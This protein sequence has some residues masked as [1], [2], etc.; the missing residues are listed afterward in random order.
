VSI[1]DHLPLVLVR[2]QLQTTA[3]P[4]PEQ[5]YFEQPNSVRDYLSVADDHLHMD[6]AIGSELYPTPNTLIPPTAA[7]PAAYTGVHPQ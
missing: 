6:G 1:A 2:P 7:A 3:N 5:Y 4:E